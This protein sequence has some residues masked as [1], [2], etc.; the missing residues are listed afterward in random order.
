MLQSREYVHDVASG[1]VGRISRLY[2]GS[3]RNGL[4]VES[5]DESRPYR[6]YLWQSQTYV[7]RGEEEVEVITQA[8]YEA[9]QDAFAR[10]HIAKTT[11]YP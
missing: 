10:Q 4:I 11:I 9:A 6:I 3:R 1:E 8:E 2:I 5:P 7:W